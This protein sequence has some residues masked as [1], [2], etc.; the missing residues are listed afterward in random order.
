M[1]MATLGGLGEPEDGERFTSRPACSARATS[2]AD[3]SLPTMDSMEKPNF[4]FG[5]GVGIMVSGGDT[6]PGSTT[7]HDIN[8]GYPLA[9]VQ[10]SQR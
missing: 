1:G 10:R 7:D 8:E 4:G 9:E 2:S 3:K 6:I 5:A